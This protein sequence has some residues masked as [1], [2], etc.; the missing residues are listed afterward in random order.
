[1]DG[2]S[3]GGRYRLLEP[4]GAGGT[5]AVWRATDE[6]TGRPVA[7]KLLHPHLAADPE[8]RER[9]QREALAMGGIDHPNVVAVRDLILDGDRPALIMD[10]VDGQSLAEA[11]ATTGALPEDEA[12]R[13]ASEVAT[14]LAAV[15]A[16]GL[17]HRD[18]KPANILLGAD[19][20]ARVTDLGIAANADP[21]DAAITAT[22]GVAGTLRYLA[23]ERLLG[24][25]AVTA[26]DVWGLGVV[27]VEMLTG[28]P[29]FPT[30][31]IEARVGAAGQ[32]VVR[33]EGIAEPAWT[34]I[35]RA[36]AGDPAARYPTAEAMAVDLRRLAP[37]PLAVAPGPVV[38]PWADT[39]VIP[40][41]AAVPIPLPTLG[42]VPA[43]IVVPSAA[44]E[45]AAG[46]R[47]LPLIP[48]LGAAV[49]VLLIAVAALGGA[50]GDAPGGSGDPA[51]GASAPASTNVIATAPPS[52]AV[53][54]ATPPPNGD[55]K[56]GKG[57]GNGKGK[58]NGKD[59]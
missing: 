52:A 15:H 5:A 35:E 58:G 9:L 12:L 7:V 51:A 43:P 21:G 53:G 8:A 54:G 40:L 19:G 1:M 17:V 18:L 26:T 41:P 46:R 31:S 38:D 28:E 47:G 11:I 22:D 24:A 39:A 14:G 57:R 34:I 32:G 4:A 30:S 44:A 59:D 10:F 13:I 50:G 37:V 42:T 16:A 3:I 55:D 33:P 2:R 36:T 45:P 20:R 6:R 49:L 56:P 27:L 23:P 48:V 29:A 25:P